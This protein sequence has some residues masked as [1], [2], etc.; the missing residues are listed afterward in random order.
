[1]A[2]LKKLPAAISGTQLSLERCGLRVWGQ[3]ERKK[4]ELAMS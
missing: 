3:M 1:M 4:E 2:Y